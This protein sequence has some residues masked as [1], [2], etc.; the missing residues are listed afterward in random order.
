MLTLPP[1]KLERLLDITRQMAETR[2]LEPLLKRAMASA[3]DLVG[4]EMGY[5]ILLEADDS[6][7]FPVR[8]HRDGSV[9]E[10]PDTQVSQSILRKVVFDGEDVLLADALGDGEFNASKSVMLLRLRSVMSVPLVSREVTLGAIY[11][12]NRTQQNVFSHGDLKL[13]KFF[14]AQ[15]AVMIDNAMLN[16]DL[17]QRVALRTQELE[18]ANNQLEANWAEAVEVNRMRA[19][20][21]STV[22]HD[23][24]SPLSSVMTTHALLLDGSVGEVD[25]DQRHMLELAQRTLDHVIKLTNDI[26]DLSKLEMGQ[27]EIY[28]EPVLAMDYLRSLYETGQFLPWKEGV[29]FRLETRGD[30]P[31]V[32]VD[33]TRIQQVV[34]NLLT[35]AAKFTDSGTVTLYAHLAESGE[36]LVIG[37]RDTGVGISPDE[38]DAVFA[39]FTQGGT[40]LMRQQGTGL[41]LAISQELVRLH[42]GSIQ[43]Q[44]TLGQG[45]DFW[46]E[47]P[48]FQI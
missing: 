36:E 8:L 1:D 17:E 47:L 26:F 40:R 5:L 37:V 14:A 4:A 42:G 11:V 6:L 33:T 46:F 44:S 30:L 43:V 10:R 12:E 28:P 19:D 48:L 2:V 34:V 24:R 15:A 29:D 3:L 38:M 18:D 35:N 20:F 21:L 45:S 27:L 23:I 9:V 16:E 39:R 41:G 32:D 25:D 31:I 13:L 7:S 22:V